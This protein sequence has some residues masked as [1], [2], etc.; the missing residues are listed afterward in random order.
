ML[1]ENKAENPM[2]T[3][4]TAEELAEDFTTFFLEKKST[5][6]RNNSKQH[7]HI[8]QHHQKY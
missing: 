5:K 1:T 4:K 7:Q 6:Y 2:P 3:G 8:D